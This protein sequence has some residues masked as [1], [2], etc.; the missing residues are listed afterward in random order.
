MHF[1]CAHT[2]LE[3][4]RNFTVRVPDR[5]Q[6]QDVTLPRCEEIGVDFFLYR[7]DFSA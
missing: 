1:D 7:Q 2:D 3:H 4:F 6:T 5:Y